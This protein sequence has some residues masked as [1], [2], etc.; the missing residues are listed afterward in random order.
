MEFQRLNPDGLSAP[1]GG[2]YSHVVRAGDTVYI[3]GQLARDAAG[4][5]LG[6]GD[7]AVQYRQLWANLGTA[8]ASVGL[9]FDNLVKTTTYVVGE[10][11][12]A[13]LRAVRAELSPSKP[14]TSTMVVVAG[15]AIP[16]ALVEVDAVAVFTS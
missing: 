3:S 16:D 15:L 2:M 13:P 12:L 9:S 6:K 5:L 1:P 7:V 8:L 11:N 4:N 10:S 14:P